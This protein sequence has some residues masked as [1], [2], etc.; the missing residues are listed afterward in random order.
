M[1]DEILDIVRS[2]QS[3]DEVRLSPTN[4][5]ERNVHHLFKQANDV[6]V[7]ARQAVG[8]PTRDQRRKIENDIAR[9]L[10]KFQVE[11]VDFDWY[12]SEDLQVLIDQEASLATPSALILAGAECAKRYPFVTLVQKHV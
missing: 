10:G 2:L 7:W 11:V 12:S 1:I 5:W 9:F 4:E 8:Q 6:P 3:H